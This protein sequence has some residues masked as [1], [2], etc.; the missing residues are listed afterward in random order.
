M[1]S[2]C[3]G[4]NDGEEEKIDIPPLPGRFL[5]DFNNYTLLESEV[6]KLL[7]EQLYRQIK[8]RPPTHGHLAQCEVTEP[9]VFTKVVEPGFV[10][11]EGKP[12]AS[13][14]KY[15]AYQMIEPETKAVRAVGVFC[16]DTR[17]GDFYMAFGSA[18]VMARPENDP[19]RLVD[20]FFR[21]ILCHIGLKRSI[22]STEGTWST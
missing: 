11:Q 18:D 19:Q 21:R 22:D 4:V 17:L 15:Y 3:P 8:I 16:D 12:Q 7:Q 10:T 5:D 2:G 9:E 14:I 20:G 6:R 13:I 1:L